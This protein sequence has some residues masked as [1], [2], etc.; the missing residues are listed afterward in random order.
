MSQFVLLANSS[1][2]LEQHDEAC[3]YFE[4]ALSIC[5]VLNGDFTETTAYSMIQLANAYQ[6]SFR[7]QDAINILEHAGMI[8]S[9]LETQKLTLAGTKIKEED[10][11]RIALQLNKLYVQLINLYMG[12]DRRAE[13]DQLI[14]QAEGRLEQCLEDLYT[15]KLMN[16]LGNCLRKHDDLPT[17]VQLYKKSLLSIK[18][19]CKNDYLQMRDTAKILINIAST[20][21]M[22]DENVESLRYYQHALNVLKN[23]PDYPAREI[24]DFRRHGGRSEPEFL[25]RPEQVTLAVDLA[26]VHVSI[27]HLQ[28]QFGEMGKAHSHFIEAI[29][30]IKPHFLH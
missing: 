11:K 23:C 12:L 13:A 20:E 29:V 22:Q 30:S 26:K 16:E 14:S 9:K 6:L 25:L 1:Q 28:K 18:I 24:A 17:A 10:R 8:L 4:K 15:F 3:C 21:F 5:R 2:K 27:G 19:R 7:A